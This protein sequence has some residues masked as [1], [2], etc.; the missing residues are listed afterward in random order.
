MTFLFQKRSTGF[1]LS[2]K[3]TFNDIYVRTYTQIQ[4][5]A[6]YVRVRAS[7]EIGCF[8]RSISFHS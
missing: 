7:L 8:L 6:V 5:A 3:I 4:V 1:P 2:Y